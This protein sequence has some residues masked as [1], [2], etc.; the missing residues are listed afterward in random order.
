MNPTILNTPRLLL[1]EYN[2]EIQKY[3]FS[4]F[5]DEELMNYLG[6]HAPEELEKEKERVKGGYTTFNRS[7]LVFHLLD[8][9][10]QKVIGYCGYHSWAFQ[11]NRAELFYGLFDDEYKQQGLMKEAI[12]PVVKYGFQQMNLQRIEVVTGEEN[13]PS[14]KLIK[15]LGCKQEAIMRKHYCVNGVNEDSILFSLLVNEFSQ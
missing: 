15:F 1:R 5:S 14:L 13:E 11:H 6:I 10:S 8:K 3:I 7:F 4:H 2:A 12:V 9:T